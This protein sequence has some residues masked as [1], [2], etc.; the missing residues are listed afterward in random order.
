MTEALAKVDVQSR[1]SN[2]D[3]HFEGLTGAAA[4]KRLADLSDRYAK[5]VRTTDMKV[6]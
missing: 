6:D 5:V 2:L 3:L 1:L 4:V